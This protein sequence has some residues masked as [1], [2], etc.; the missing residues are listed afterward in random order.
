M[1]MKSKRKTKRNQRNYLD[2]TI[3][4]KKIK[5]KYQRNEN[6]AKSSN[7]VCLIRKESVGLELVLYNNKL[8]S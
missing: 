6:V 3:E 2:N 5:K 1:V 7:G 8:L 4:I